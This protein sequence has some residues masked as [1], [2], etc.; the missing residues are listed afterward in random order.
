MLP[1]SQFLRVV[2]ELVGVGRLPGGPVRQA[3]GSY[4][5]HVFAGDWAVMTWE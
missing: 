4:D 2:D 1:L 3:A 5:R